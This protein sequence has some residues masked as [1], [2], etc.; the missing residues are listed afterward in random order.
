MT[1]L[2]FAFAIGLMIPVQAAV[3]NQLKGFVGSSTLLAAF[4]SFTV[5][6]IALAVVATVNR[7]PWSSLGN[8]AKVEW[9]HLTG[10]LLG[11]LFVFGTTLLAPRIGLAK[12]TALIVAGQVVISL[13]M[14][15]NGW[16]GLAVREVTATRLL[17]GALV[18]AGV[19]LVNL[20][21]LLG[22]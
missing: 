8:L 4:I 16:L 20:D 6:T 19:F 7:Q 1:Y 9:W 5:G 17:G 2:A 14:D 15:H 22:R 21:Q 12:M 11:A 18:V 10:G 3:N 13:V